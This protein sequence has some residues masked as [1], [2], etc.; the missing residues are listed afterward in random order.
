MN[1]WK[2]K[3]KKGKTGNEIEPLNFPAGTQ[4]E[5]DRS[6]VTISIPPHGGGSDFVV[7]IASKVDMDRHK[8]RLFEFLGKTLQAQVL[9]GKGPKPRRRK[10]VVRKKPAKR[11]APTKKDKKSRKKGK[12]K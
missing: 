8:A 2:T 10:K 5:Y 3:P 4:V 1:E 12:K 7:H 11:K 9:P 6:H